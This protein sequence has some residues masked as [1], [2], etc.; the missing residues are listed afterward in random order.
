ML[1]LNELINQN[2]KF[3][4]ILIS[5]IKNIDRYNHLSKSSL[6]VLNNF[7]EGSVSKK[8]ENHWFRLVI[9]EDSFSIPP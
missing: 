8:F 6:G 3:I 2:L 4:S 5:N 7:K 1:I 9:W